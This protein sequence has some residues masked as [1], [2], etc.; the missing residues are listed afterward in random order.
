MFKLI[1]YFNTFIALL[2]AGFV[3][4]NGQQ[5]KQNVLFSLMA[6]SIALYTVLFALSIYASDVR[7][8][9]ME[10]RVFHVFCVFYATFLFL[11]VNEIIFKNTFKKIWHCLPFISGVI[12][13]YF[14]LR[15]DV[16]KGV[17]KVGDLPNWTVPGSQFYFYWAHFG[18]FTTLS[19]ILLIINSF[20]E[21]GESRNQIRLILLA[22]VIGMAGAWMTF[23]PGLGIK[24][25]PHG[26]HLIFVALSVIAYAILKYQLMDI[27]ATLSK[28]GAL[29]VSF[30]IYSIAYLSIIYFCVAIMREN[31]RSYVFIAMTLL[32]GLGGGFYF[33]KF[34]LFLQTVAEK[35]FIK[36]W[37]DLD[38]V[39]AEIS[40]K[41]I[42]IYAL[43]N[44]FR[45]IKIKYEEVEFLGCN[46]F[47]ANKNT[48]KQDKTSLP[49]EYYL[50]EEKNGNN[51]KLDMDHLIVQYFRNNRDVLLFQNMS[52][53]I[54]RS[55][56]G[57]R[58]IK[59]SI[60][61]PFYSSDDLEAI[62]V[63][64]KKAS[65]SSFD[66]K[67][68]SLFKMTQNQVFLVLDRIRPYEKIKKDYEANQKKLYDTERLL[69]RSE[70]I[71]SLANTIREYNHEIKTP[72]SII[73]GEAALLVKEPRDP[74]YLEWFKDLVY[75]QVDRA[76]DIVE[77]TLRLSTPKE[78]KEI[79]LNLNDVM[80][81]ALKLF[82]LTGVHL[83]KELGALPSVSG[84]PE[85]LQLVFINLF[86]NAV[87]A[88]PDG[89]TLRLK[90]YWQKTGEESFAVAE[91]ADT[92]AGIPPENLDRIFE[93]F[94]SSHVTKGRGLGLSIVFRVIREHLGRIEVKS[95]VG[96]GSTFIV[97]IPVKT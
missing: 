21:E 46:V 24:I 67:D 72:L 73:R 57:Y 37:Y 27:K 9:L 97:K 2:L 74:K 85:D 48:G 14:I 23:L 1:V 50:F 31:L 30:V 82:P 96:K 20:R 15:G 89:G 17:E 47:L 94:F 78:R 18:L 63:I 7:I 64:D 10:V 90:S 49:T 45:E 39:T 43:E 66:D 68:Y 87:E 79:S 3:Y 35:A 84:D 38:K 41:L 61:I 60:Y 53:E 34:R 95:E 52:G 71:A 28:M 12:A 44:V 33:N 86:K 62:I 76:N 70:R 22:L 40:G 91:I 93:P 4:M 19:I 26:I 25:E 92:G 81:G 16:I 59:S 69:A 65:E 75:E 32:Y 8:S 11:F 36:G 54:K 51:E 56:E 6:V 13:S 5:K 42:S 88:M 83:E 80:D 55:I 58:F 29:V 77:S